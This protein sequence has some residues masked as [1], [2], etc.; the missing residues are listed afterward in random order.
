MHTA[1]CAIITEEISPERVRYKSRCPKCG[2]VDESDWLGSITCVNPQG[3]TTTSAYCSA[4]GAYFTIT[5]YGT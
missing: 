5:F 2:K 3:R 4:C 1:D